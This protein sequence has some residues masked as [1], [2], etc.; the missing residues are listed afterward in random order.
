M[1]FSDD[2]EDDKMASIEKT[3]L[4]NS[5]CLPLSLRY[6][7]PP[8]LALLPHSPWWTSD[9]SEELAAQTKQVQETFGIEHEFLYDDQFIQ[10]LQPHSHLDA[11]RA[12]A[13]I[14]GA[15]NF[16]NLPAL[17]SEE[18]D[19]HAPDI[20][21]VFTDGSFSAPRHPQYSLTSAGV[22]WPGR[23]L[24]QHPLS[25]LERDMSVDIA[26]HGGIELM[27]FVDGPVS[28]SSRAELVVLI[29][30]LFSN[31]PVHAAIDSQ[32]VLSTATK[33]LNYLS[34]LPICLSFVHG[35][36]NLL[37]TCRSFRS[38]ASCPLHRTVTFGWSSG[39]PWSQ[40]ELGGA[41]QKNEGARP[42]PQKSALPGKTP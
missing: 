30:S 20:P 18:C 25:D 5:S 39:G 4:E 10:W 42:R 21:S 32:V 6:A 9:T 23:K 28:S 15:G 11:V 8:P 14:N 40:G 17:P 37:L 29:V 13:G 31:L 1:L 36:R 24:A 33:V 38:N 16:P 22:W 3:I 7:I 27:T 2:A 26:R 35:Y 41:I 12:F 34:I 19:L